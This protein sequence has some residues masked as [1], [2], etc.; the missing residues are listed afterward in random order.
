MEG[1]PWGSQAHP[2]VSSG[3]ACRLADRQTLSTGPRF[4]C[5]GKETSC[6]AEGRTHGLHGSQ[7][8]MLSVLKLVRASYHVQ[9]RHL[10]TSMS[11]AATNWSGVTKPFSSNWSVVP[12]PVTEFC[13]PAAVS[14][15]V[16]ASNVYFHNA[17]KSERERRRQERTHHGGD[18]RL[19][20][21][22]FHLL[23]CA[24]GLQRL[25]AFHGVAPSVF[26]L[27]SPRSSSHSG[28]GE[29]CR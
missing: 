3:T 9:V 23:H 26:L 12:G 17:R 28:R 10:E 27:P 20:T 5:G 25:C 2:V 7:R 19:I 6:H 11:P 15:G 22:L 16:H 24:P 8:H 13:V 21:E 1:E 18:K 14:T 4:P 29:G